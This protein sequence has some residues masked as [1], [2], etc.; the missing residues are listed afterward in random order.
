MG[1]TR[2]FEGQ[3]AMITGAARGMGRESALAFAAE[4]AAVALTDV[5]PE[6]DGVADEVRR[7]GGTA[8]SVVGDV[9]DPAIVNRLAA[10]ARAELGPVTVLHNNAGFFFGAPLE[11]HSVEDFRRLLD[12]NCLAQFIAIISPLGRSGVVW[13]GASPSPTSWK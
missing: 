2:R 10:A 3:V 13:G 4:G 11:D 8:V 9:S 5:L 1:S 7:A 12:V 6:V